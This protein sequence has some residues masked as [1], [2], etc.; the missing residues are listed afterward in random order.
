MKLWHSFTKELLLASRS[1]YF[2]IEVV[3]A[4]IFLFLL[5]FVIPEK[6]ESKQD[7]YLYYD[8]TEEA[9]PFFEE[10]L[11]G[12]DLDG[13]PEIVEL[14]WEEETISAALYEAE[15]NK[16]FVLD[17]QEA[18]VQIADKKHAFAGIIHLDEKGNVTY[19]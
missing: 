6:I 12:E 5:L 15:N 11:L 4:A 8:V 19:T 3:M 1:F 10:E 2:Y 17:N 18:A 14:E 7:E 13:M 9:F 16:Y